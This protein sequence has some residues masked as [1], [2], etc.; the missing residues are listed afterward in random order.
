MCKYW[1]SQKNGKCFR[2]WITWKK[3]ATIHTEI[4][5]LSTILWSCFLYI[6]LYMFWF[7]WW[8]VFISSSPKCESPLCYCVK[9]KSIKIWSLLHL[10]CQSL[11]D[12]LVLIPFTIIAYVSTVLLIF[13]SFVA[14]IRVIKVCT[15]GIRYVSWMNAFCYPKHLSAMVW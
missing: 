15:G 14:A 12:S 11:I 10:E 13:L 5:S 2:S 4:T 9:N 3:N 1:I 8:P 6:N 7:P